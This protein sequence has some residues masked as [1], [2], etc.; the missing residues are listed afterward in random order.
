[1]QLWSA[2]ALLGLDIKWIDKG[3]TWSQF[4]IHVAL[5]G[6]GGVR[7]EKISSLD[8]NNLAEVR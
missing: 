2:Y 4:H 8:L 5:P 7:Q 1:M 6:Q 3:H